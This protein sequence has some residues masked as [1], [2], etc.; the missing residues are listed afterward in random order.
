MLRAALENADR[1]DCKKKRGRD[2]GGAIGSLGSMKKSKR[3]LDLASLDQEYSTSQCCSEDG[4]ENAEEAHD[5]SFFDDLCSADV[6]DVDD[7]HLAIGLGSI[8]LTLDKQFVLCCKDE[9][10]ENTIDQGTPT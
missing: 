9:E 1:S 10:D 2:G 5:Y 3:S 6:A 7:Q 4:I 8:R